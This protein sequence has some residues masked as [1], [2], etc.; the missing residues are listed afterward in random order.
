M[1]KYRSCITATQKFINSFRIELSIDDIASSLLT[2]ADN[3]LHESN[4]Y[5]K[6]GPENRRNDTGQ[7][8]IPYLSMR[9]VQSPKIKTLSGIG[10]FYQK[11]QSHVGFIEPTI[12]YNYALNNYIN[13]NDNVKIRSKRENNIGTESL[14]N[15][16][17]N[18]ELMMRDDID[19]SATESTIE[20]SSLIEDS[21]KDDIIKHEKLKPIIRESL[22]VSNIDEG[23]SVMN[24]TKE[25]L[26]KK[27]ISKPRFIEHCEMIEVI[28]EEST[29]EAITEGE[30]IPA[31]F[32]KHSSYEHTNEEKQDFIELSSE[33]PTSISTTEVV[34]EEIMTK[35]ST[36]SSIMEQEQNSQIIAIN[37]PVTDA[38]STEDTEI[39][40]MGMRENNK[41]DE[42]Y[43]TTFEVITT[44]LP[45]EEKIVTESTTEINIEEQNNIIQ[46]HLMKESTAVV[47]TTEEDVTKSSV[48]EINN[49][50]KP[51]SQSVKGS[52]NALKIQIMFYIIALLVIISL[53]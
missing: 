25:D 13:I 33:K 4:T 52:A 20:E 43:E 39:S 12:Y 46:E 10:L 29:P 24:K 27:G 51:Q 14:E 19:K 31:A 17:E 36:E 7:F 32:L 2:N 23:H 37:E 11:P 50:V 35:T 30:T 41:A 48:N 45:E 6:F 49:L 15:I 8:T 40:A 22:L 1:Y 3:K 9:N 28:T 18:S 44:K 47:S 16:I 21:V 34:T 53:V 38:V 42:I 26:N 5:I